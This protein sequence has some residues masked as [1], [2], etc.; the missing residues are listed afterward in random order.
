MDIAKAIAEQ[1]GLEIDR[2]QISLERPI[3]STGNFEIDV[4]LG[5]DVSATIK[6]SVTAAGD[7]SSAEGD[8]SAE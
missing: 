3:K 6:L 5:H 4:K 1:A 2:H 7:S 8:D